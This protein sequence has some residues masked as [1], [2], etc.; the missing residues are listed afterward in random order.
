MPSG[1]QHVGPG[2]GEITRTKASA[3]NFER[4]LR[5][6]IESHYNHP[7]IVMWVPFNEG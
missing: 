5:L 2:K 3:D 7:S 1:D 4:E 6:M